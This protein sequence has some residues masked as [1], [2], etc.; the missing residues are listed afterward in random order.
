MGRIHI[1]I[2]YLKLLEPLGVNTYLQQGLGQSLESNIFI[3][4][5]PNMRVFTVS[6][7]SNLL[8]L[9]LAKKTSVF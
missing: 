4:L 6:R 8:T 5:Q 3:F 1:S 9:D 7:G 2:P